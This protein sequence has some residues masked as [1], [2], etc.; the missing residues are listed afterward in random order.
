MEKVYHVDFLLDIDDLTIGLI[1][2][3]DRNQGLWGHGIEEPL[4]A[5]ENITIKHSGIKI[6][7]KNYDSIAFI[8]NDIKF[9]QFKLSAD[10]ELLEWASNWDISEDDEIT[11]NV[12]GEVSINTY[13]GISTAQFTIRESM[14]V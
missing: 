5:V 11:L 4:V 14:I 3:I 10:N 12:V 7:G 1:Q 6:Q 2:E 13:K 8:V 9:V